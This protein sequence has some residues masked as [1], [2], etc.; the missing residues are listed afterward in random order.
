MNPKMPAYRCLLEQFQAED[1]NRSG[2]ALDGEIPAGQ[3]VQLLPSHLDG[4]EH[5]RLLLNIPLEPG[6]DRLGLLAGDL[7]NRMLLEDPPFPIKSIGALPEPDF[8]P[9]FLIMGLEELGQSGGPSH[10]QGQNPSRHGVESS[11]MTHLD[12]Q[13]LAHL[14][15][16]ILRGR[17]TGFIGDQDAAGWFM[18][19]GVFPISQSLFRRPLPGFLLPKDRPH[20]YGPRHP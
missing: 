19:Q 5:G 18:N 7:R 14:G 4:R 16:D 20:S 6:Q 15:N 13:E 9:I 2:R 10:N 12:L 11:G 8:S 17:P 1:G 3:V